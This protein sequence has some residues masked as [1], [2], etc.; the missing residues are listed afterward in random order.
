MVSS[1]E[2]GLDS[3]SEELSPLWHYSLLSLVAHFLGSIELNQHHNAT[4]SR[5]WAAPGVLI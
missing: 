2:D 5:I 3:I 1:D 4:P